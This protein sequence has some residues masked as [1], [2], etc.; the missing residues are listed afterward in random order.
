M[1]QDEVSYQHSQMTSMSQ[2]HRATKRNRSKE[3]SSSCR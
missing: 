1:N 3:G 2:W